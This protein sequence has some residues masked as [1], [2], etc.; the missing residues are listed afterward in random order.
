MEQLICVSHSFSLLCNI[1]MLL[2]LLIPLM[3]TQC[4]T[5]QTVNGKW[6]EL[7]TGVCS[8]LVVDLVTIYMVKNN[9]LIICC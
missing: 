1:S 4:K 8:T 3:Y 6:A 7:D 9:Y 2:H 5:V